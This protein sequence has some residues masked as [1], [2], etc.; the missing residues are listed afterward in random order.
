ML[1]KLAS[2]MVCLVMIL[3]PWISNAV[4]A[5][6]DDDF[7]ILDDRGLGESEDGDVELSG[8]SAPVG[9]TRPRTD[10]DDG[11]GP[12]KAPVDAQSDKPPPKRFEPSERVSEDLSVSFPADI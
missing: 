3:G 7:I 8:R 4:L 9:Q 2:L 6:D 1:S 11:A 5:Q 12:V 10:S